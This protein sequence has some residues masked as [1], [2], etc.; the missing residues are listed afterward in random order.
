MQRRRRPL[1]P[2]ARANSS[3]GA[4]VIFR[5]LVSATPCRFDCSFFRLP[6]EEEEEEAAEVEAEF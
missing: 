6:L 2:Q 1:P 3:D 4:G 5:I